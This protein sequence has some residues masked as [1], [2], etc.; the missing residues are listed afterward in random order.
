MRALAILS[1]FALI[2]CESGDPCDVDGATRCSEDAAQTCTNGAWETTDDCAADGAS[3]MQMA[4]M[5]D[6]EAHCM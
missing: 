6:G 4:D 3:C 2:A 5:A 1:L